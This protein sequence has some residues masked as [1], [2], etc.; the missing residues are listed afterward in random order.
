MFLHNLDV[1]LYDKVSPTVANHRQMTLPRLIPK[2]K[3]KNIT[4]RR[5]PPANEATPHTALSP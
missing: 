2:T 1:E 3:N 5:H 4:P